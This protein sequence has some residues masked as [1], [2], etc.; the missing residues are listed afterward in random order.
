MINFNFEELRK[1][2]VGWDGYDAPTPSEGSIFKTSIILPNLMNFG[3]EPVRIMASAEGGTAI[4]FK[5]V[6]IRRALIE[7]LN[8]GAITTLLYDMDGHAF[9]FEWADTSEEEAQKSAEQI[10]DWLKEN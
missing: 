6:D 4:I 5:G 2:E 9:M 7:I 10:L 3:V 8:D 1:L